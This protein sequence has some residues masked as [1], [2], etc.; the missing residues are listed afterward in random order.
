M[1]WFGLERVGL[2]V[3]APPPPGW[4]GEGWVG[5]PLSLDSV[6]LVFSLVWIVLL[7]FWW[8]GLLPWVATLGRR[9]H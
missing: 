5:S 2:F 7:A 1:F 6:G 3:F 9:M 4:F 8:F